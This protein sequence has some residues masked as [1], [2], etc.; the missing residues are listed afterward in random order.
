[1][2][3]EI[4]IYPKKILKM[5]RGEIHMP[6]F[7]CTG[8]SET[9]LRSAWLRWKRGF[10]RVASACGETNKIKLR[11]LLLAYAG[12]ELQ[13][14][15]HD[16]MEG[17][18]KDP[19]S[20]DFVESDDPLKEALDLLDEHFMP[21]R[22]ESYER[23]IF[24]TL[25][26]KPEEPYLE[27][28]LRA[29]R[30]L[31]KCKF[32]KTE[33]EQRANAMVDKIILTADEEIR[34]KLLA[35]KDMDLD[36]V[37]RLVKGFL[38]AKTASNEIGKGKPSTSSG[39]AN[40]GSQSS[41]YQIKENGG[42]F[43]AKGECYRCGRTGHYGKDPKCP[44][45]DKICSK[46]SLKG[47]L[48]AKCRTKRAIKRPNEQNTVSIPTKRVRVNAVEDVSKREEE[49]SD[50][51]FIFNVGDGDEFIW[52]QIGGV[53]IEMLIDSGSSQN[54]IDETTW[55]YMQNNGIQ[56]QDV[57]GQNSPKQLRAYAQTEPLR[58]MKIFKAN[59][60]VVGAKTGVSCNTT[61]YVV[62]GG[63][64]SLL[65][66]STAKYLGVLVLGLPNTSDQLIGQIE[67][68]RITPFPK[69]KGIKIV[70]PIDK[71]VTPVTQHVRRPPIALLSKVEE[72]LDELLKSD[73]I[74]PV[75]GPSEWVSPIVVIPKDNGDIRL[76]VDMRQ[77]NKA[78]KRENHM[79]PVL[80]DF[81][82]KLGS[83]RIFSRLDIKN[84]FHQMELEP[85]SR[86][87]T[88]FITH[89]GM[90]R[91]RRVIYK[92]GSSNIADPFSRLPETTVNTPDFDPAEEMFVRTILESAAIDV[93]EIEKA[94]QDDPEV[95][96]LR[97][98]ID[99]GRWS[100]AILK[101]FQAFKLEYGC[102]GNCVIRGNK[103]V[104][105]KNLRKR[106]L[107]LAHEGHPGETAMKRR[108]RDRVWWPGID[109]DVVKM[110]QLCEGCRLVSIPNKPEP[111]IRRELPVGPWI[112]LAI[113]YL[114]P[115]P[116]GEYL[117]V[118]IDYFSR[119]KEIEITNKITAR[120]TILRLDKIFTRLG[121]PRTITLDNAKQFVSSELEE[122]CREKGICLN[123]TIPYWPQQNGEVERQNRSL[124]KRIR[125]S[126][127][128]D[129]DWKKDLQDYLVMY[130]T[131]PHSTTGK[132]PTELCYGRTIRG[133]IPSLGDLETSPPSTD[134]RDKDKFEKEKGRESE[135]AKR[136]AKTSGIVV[137]DVVVARNL[138]P[139][140][141]LQSVFGRTQYKVLRK[142]GAA[143]L[144]QDLET[145]KQ[146][147]RNV[148]HLKKVPEGQPENALHR[149]RSDFDLDP[150]FCIQ[151]AV[152]TERLPSASTCLNLLK[153][154]PFQN[155]E[156]LRIKLLYA[157]DSGSGFELS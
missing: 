103:F 100:D 61:F 1:M 116:S 39:M 95:Q 67:D 47:H 115:L 23:N 20:E 107:N 125:I 62:A 109:L 69:M 43:Q 58:I 140:N 111:M 156:T 87:I 75:H 60:S 24:W 17:K 32:G 38:S 15:Y 123:N 41:V 119:Y 33:Q 101:P 82:P 73:I 135:D 8:F 151:D 27:F 145:G 71:S 40:T 5:Q 56:I 91:Y 133:K 128:L 78:I 14:V 6:E 94:S 77:V 72:K 25:T 4:G 152:N 2:F 57:E 3:S 110:V 22:H 121:Y 90:F 52:C 84:A 51:S 137:G 50:S 42:K 139:G 66:K 102:V 46:C 16:L 36:E 142:S 150:P 34:T 11:D 31:N 70:I 130:Y 153:L 12:F 112:D 124:L 13:E 81:L 63:S 49:K 19:D 89:K 105:P 97:Q 108:L 28:L 129:R 35:K 154:P 147:E 44:A 59:I 138:Q 37:L 118:V 79:M 80:E 134:Y 10:M 106:M 104:V 45:R 53:L 74:E 92:K 127:N 117:L 136:K 7:K 30:Q 76:C 9:D 48:A 143:V 141:K 68:Q 155:E 93:T 113:D 144:I 99:S 126:H 96:A 86:H 98:A 157:I 65:G 149:K 83:A 131:T 148:S 54:I 88:T 146:L 64:Q 132:T 114:G 122:Y 18:G 85:N 26:Q 120:E 55:Q 21:K 29:Q